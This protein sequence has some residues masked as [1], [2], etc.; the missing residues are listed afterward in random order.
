MTLQYSALQ[1][2]YD[3]AETIGSGKNEIN[4]TKLLKFSIMK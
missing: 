3:I 1:N 2:S 4:K